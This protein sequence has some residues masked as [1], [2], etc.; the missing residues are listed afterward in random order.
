MKKFM[1]KKDTKLDVMIM[2]FF[3]L[4]FIVL[5]QVL[6]YESHYR[7]LIMPMY[8][9]LCIQVELYFLYL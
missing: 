8:L 6:G 3:F 2:L 1:K 4:F 9:Y 7:W 5:F